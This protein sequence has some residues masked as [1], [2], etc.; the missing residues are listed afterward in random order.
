[1]KGSEN[2]MKMESLGRLCFQK[3]YCKMCKDEF[4]SF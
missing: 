2:Q 4:S 3:V 1:M